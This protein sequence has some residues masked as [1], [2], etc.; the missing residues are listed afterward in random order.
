MGFNGQ[1]RFTSSFQITWRQLRL[2]LAG[3]MVVAVGC[4]SA[5]S[6]NASTTDPEIAPATDSAVPPTTNPDESSTT[7]TTALSIDDIE[8]EP[9]D[10]N[11]ANLPV[12]QVQDFGPAPEVPTGELSQDVVDN[13]NFVFGED[14]G[15]GFGEEEVAALVELG[16]SGDPRVAWLMSDL[17]RLAGGTDLTAPLVEAST[18]VTGTEIDPF[19]P[20]LDLTDRLI[21]WD[22]PAPPGYI[23]WK[24]N[25]YTLVVPEWEPLFDPTAT[26]IDWRYI[27]WGGV[28]IDDRAYSSPDQFDPICSCIPAIDNPEV[29]DVA[30]AGWLDDDDVVF[31][32]TLNGESRAYPR[33]AMEVREMVNDTLGGRDLG[34]PYC[35][36]CGS[37]QA[38][39]TDEVP[40]GV[41]RPILRTSGLLS[42]SNKV[43]YD[44]NSQSVFDTFLGTALTGPLSEIG[45]TL[46]QAS[47][48]TTTWGDWR[49]AHPDTTVLAEGLNL[50]RDPDFRS[51]RD[52]NG[53]IF[54][55]GDVDPRLDI[56]EDVVGVIT[57]SGEP[58]AF[59]SQTARFALQDGQTVVADGVE[60]RLVSGGLQAFTIDGDP[61][62]TH[63]SFWFAWSQF[64]PDTALWPS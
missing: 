28:G 63:E 57:P 36:L 19:D 18:E 58:L 1:V 48:L 49:E 56:Q 12:G 10:V 5:T 29:T 39:F 7:D 22:V 50:G 41:E 43:M 21:A 24:S 8:T 46:E 11:P 23:E 31:G 6:D 3:L 16:G 38:Y 20:W 27:S 17:L 33:S 45:V 62:S 61:I 53:P 4:S 15:T 14:F 13:L 44:L 26:D 34:I 42:R 40:E 47:V 9:F 54:P 35:T 37:A 55:V 2:T 51:N 60:L 59:H 64:N 52:A 32:I 25:I 30:G